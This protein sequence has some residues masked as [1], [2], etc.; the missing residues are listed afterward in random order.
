VNERNAIE[1]ITGLR[2]FKPSPAYNDSGVEWLREIPSEWQA[3]KLK[4]VCRVAYGDS[5]VTDS[6]LGGDIEVCGSNGPVDTHGRSDFKRWVL[7]SVTEKVVRH[8][9]DPVL[10]VR[11]A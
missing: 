7:G 6:R 4:R 11:A 1:S 9:R 8:S 3:L 2:K 10:V 5:L